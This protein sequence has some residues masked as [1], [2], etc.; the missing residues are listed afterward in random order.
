MPKKKIDWL[1]HGLEFLVVIVGIL[2]AFQLNKCSETRSTEKLLQ[3]HINYI[4]IECDENKN[5][6]EQGSK[7]TNQQIVAADSLLVAISKKK[8]INLIRQLGVQLLNLQNVDIKRDAYSVLLESG[9]IRFFKDYNKKRAVISLYE[10]MQKVN[11][12]NENIQKLYD[13]HFY[14][15][16]K[17]N[18]DMVD[19]DYLNASDEKQNQPYHS[20]E[21]GNIISTYRF[22]L[23][24]KMNAYDEVAG[25]LK[26]YIK[27]E[28]E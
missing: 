26:N 18:F 25:A 1:N 7:H 3:N 6:L 19:W 17:E 10:N 11:T 5:M 28:K 20:K 15:Y 22:L 9:D 12:V 27:K 21:F 14:P 16:L 2:L 24:A 4:E 8:N 13:N 23:V